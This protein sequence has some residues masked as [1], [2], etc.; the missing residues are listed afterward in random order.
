VNYDE[1]Y[2]DP[3][4]RCKHGTFIGSWWGPDYLCMDCELGVG[5]REWVLGSAH[6][7]LLRA[8]ASMNQ[9]SLNFWMDDEKWSTNEW[10]LALP[11]DLRWSLANI[12]VR[13]ILDHYDHLAYWGKQVRHARM[14]LNALQRL[15]EDSPRF[16]LERV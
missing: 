11:L 4:Q 14:R 10:F 13:I 3:A 6:L 16:T 15:P 1:D 2:N 5:D 8:E 7:A 9:H 12:R